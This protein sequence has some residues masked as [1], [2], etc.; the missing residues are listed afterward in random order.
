LLGLTESY[1]KINGAYYTPETVAA[2]LVR[3]AVRTTKGLSAIHWWHES[4][5]CGLQMRQY[6]MTSFLVGFRSEPRDSTAWWAIHRS[7]DTSDLPA[8]PGNPPSTIVLVM[9]FAFLAWHRPGPHS[10]LRPQPH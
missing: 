1:Q 7:F 3:W 4:R 6:M 10:W 8:L 9:A 2:T 5:G